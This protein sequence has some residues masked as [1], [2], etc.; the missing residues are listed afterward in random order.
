MELTGI[1]TIPVP[2]LIDALA[3]RE[4]RARVDEPAPAIL[5][6]RGSADVFCEGLD[7]KEMC[8]PGGIRTGLDGYA[9]L[10]NALRT[11]PHPVVAII[12]GRACGGGVGLAAASDLALASEQAT[13]TL[14]E[15][16]FGMMP[17][18][19]YPFLLERI[20]PQKAK[21]WALAADTLAAA[22]ARR[23]GLVDEVAPPAQI[24][25]MLRN[26]TRRLSR[27]KPGAVEAWKKYTAR[28][29][30]ASLPTA[31]EAGAERMLHPETI[32][33]VRRFIEE[34]AAPWH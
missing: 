20:P 23:I 17:A 21:L 24:D 10:L 9:A 8:Q 16:L 3:L 12:E 32:S 27:V 11:C 5:V 18:V 22:Q 13:F 25:S 15:L 6:L 33:A 7:F 30:A 14:S 1:R 31:V 26:W 2:P 34:G 28:F 29:P 4:L 19:V